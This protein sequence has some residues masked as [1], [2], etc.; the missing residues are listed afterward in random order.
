MYA[1]FFQHSTPA[2]TN[3]TNYEV[4][5][6]PESPNQNRGKLQMC[7]NGIWGVFCNGAFRGRAA[8]VVCN[9]LGHQRKG[10]MHTIIMIRYG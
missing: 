8:E 4:R 7:F 6:D 1:E 9:Q 5:F 2:V 3:C 10:V